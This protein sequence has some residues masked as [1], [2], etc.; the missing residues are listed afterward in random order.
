MSFFQFVFMGE[1]K[2]IMEIFV[3]KRIMD[4]QL[5]FILNHRKW[6]CKIIQVTLYPLV[7]IHR[8]FCFWNYII[9]LALVFRTS[10][11]FVFTPIHT[12]KLLIPNPTYRVSNHYW[13]LEFLAFSL[14]PIDTVLP[15]NPDGFNISQD[16]YIPPKQNKYT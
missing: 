9:K 10:T 7:N 8:D 4:F 14:T 16:T 3:F 6:N 15:P 1:N 13:S 12:D 5:Y 11:N 2:W